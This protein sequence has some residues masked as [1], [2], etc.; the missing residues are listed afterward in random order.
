MKGICPNCEKETEL[1]LVNELETVDV[2]GEAIEVEAE[3]FRCTECTVEFEN[4]RGPDALEAAYREYRRRRHMLQPEEIRGWR[5]QHGLT[6]K[7]LARLLSWGDVTLSRYENGALQDEAHEKIL[8]LAMEPHNLLQ[9]IKETPGALSPVKQQRLI[10]ELELEEQQ[11]CSFE[12]LLEERLG[13]YGPDEL[14]GYR[15]L[16]VQKLFHTILFFCSGEGQLK[17]KL[18][19]LLFY[20]DFLHF[21][22]YTVSITGARYAHLPFG[23][24]PDNYERFFAELVDEQ[25]LSIEPAIMGPYVGENCVA[26]LEPDLSMFEA[27]EIRILAEVKDRFKTFSSTEI[28]DFSHAEAGYTETAPAERISYSYAE[29]LQIG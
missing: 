14:S 1:E 26:Q 16:D 21:K 11:A 3:Y 27:S 12:R 28:T 6:Q 23:P 20:A 4:T 17:T 8:R 24:V 5:K 19:K 9:L 15:M 25:R 22:R 2:R 29:Q 10:E 13:R 7:E 18:N